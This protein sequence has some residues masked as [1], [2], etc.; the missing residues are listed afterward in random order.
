MAQ[1]E[2]IF[3]TLKQDH[4]KHR[5]LLDKI[6][7]TSGDSEERRELFEMFT[8]DVKSHAAA[9]EQA[10]YATML[11]KPETTDETRHSVAE[12]QELD[13][14]LNDL[15]ATDMS[16]GA[17]LQ[18]FKQLKHDY[19]HH[20]EEEEEDHFPDFSEHLTSEDEKQMAEAFER[21]KS[22]EKKEAEVTPEKKSD[23]KE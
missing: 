16:T 21:R 23:A 20:I 11:R 7:N 5:E 15:A 12:H 4:N 2:T 8:K 17:W 19:L 22:A 3:K 18:K 14:A 6:E 1:A 13:E 9:E 10:V